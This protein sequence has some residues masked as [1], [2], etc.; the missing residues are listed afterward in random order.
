M[1]RAD[2]VA[3]GVDGVEVADG[4]RPLNFTFF[5]GL[6]CQGILAS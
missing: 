2:A 3:N 5:L 1:G 6:N 4:N